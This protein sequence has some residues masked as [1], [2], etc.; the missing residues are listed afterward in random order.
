MFKEHIHPT[1]LPL[2]SEDLDLCQRVFNTIRT[3]L[4]MPKKSPES[5]LLASHIINFYKRGVR[6]ETHLLLMARTAAIS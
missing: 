5:D 6:D 1:D 2:F 4:D 3:E